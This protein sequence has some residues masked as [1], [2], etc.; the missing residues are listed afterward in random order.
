M[1]QHA[2]L[3]SEISGDG[4]ISEAS[5]SYLEQRALSQFYD[6]VMARFEAEE[7][8]SNLTKARLARRIQRGQ[9][10]VNRLLASPG[11]WTIATVARL[12]AGISGEEPV[13]SSGPLFGLSPQN[14]TVM[15]LLESTTIP[16]PVILKRPLASEATPTYSSSSNIALRLM[17]Q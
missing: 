4:P 7:S 9:D 15:D 5:L 1:S 17:K 3:Q 11:N 2:Q 6:Y 12:L 16:A 10:Q 13:L 8:K 14:M